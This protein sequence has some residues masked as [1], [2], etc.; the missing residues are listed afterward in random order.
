[1][2]CH[3][4]LFIAF[5]RRTGCMMP[6]L[7]TDRLLLRPF[8]AEDAA[9]LV[10]LA[11]NWNIA[12][13]TTR[14]PHPYTR[15]I[16]DRWIASQAADRQ[17]GDEIIFCIELHGAAI[18]AVG[19]K[20][21]AAGEYE[22]GYWLGE[23]WWGRGYATEAAARAARFAFDELGAGRLTAG[24]FLDNPA[25]GQVLEKCGFRYTGE[26]VEHCAARG[27]TAAHR[28]LECGRAEFEGQV[29]GS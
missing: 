24:H 25:S 28:N 27:E 7:E 17:S 29:E 10:A 15:D 11:D 16:A 8:R 26:G 2:G 21:S 5:L 6:T 3:L 1:M 4:P 22:L 14:I 13:M 9:A 20:R 12:R 18:G 23:A 19:L